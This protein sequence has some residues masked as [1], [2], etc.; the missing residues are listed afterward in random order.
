MPI[1]YLQ[2]MYCSTWSFYCTLVYTSTFGTKTATSKLEGMRVPN[3]VNQSSRP[4]HVHLLRLQYLLLR[5]LPP[6]MARPP[7]VK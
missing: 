4:R 2:H 7:V 5:C 6:P 1:V 3:S